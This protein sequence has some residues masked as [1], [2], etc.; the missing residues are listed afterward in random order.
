MGTM[1]GVSECG[2]RRAFDRTWRCIGS[3]CIPKT[4]K[5]W[6]LHSDR[7]ALPAHYSYKVTWP[8]IQP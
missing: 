5:Y 8:D 7:G 6:L 2:R 4:L 3:V 1:Y